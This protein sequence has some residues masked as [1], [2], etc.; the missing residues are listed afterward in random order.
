MI[1]IVSIQRNNNNIIVFYIRY[2]VDT[3]SNRQVVYVIQNKLINI[4]GTF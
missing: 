3:I 4:Y 1:I 2:Q